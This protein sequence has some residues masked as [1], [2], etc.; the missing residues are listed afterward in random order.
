MIIAGLVDIEEIDVID[1]IVKV[2]SIGSRIR[3]LGSI[4]S[5]KTKIENKI[6]QEEII[7]DLIEEFLDDVSYQEV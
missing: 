4:E 5:Q 7:D 1:Q 2:S 3:G 6:L